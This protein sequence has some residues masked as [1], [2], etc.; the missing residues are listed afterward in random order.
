MHSMKFLKATD[1][2]SGAFGTVIYQLLQTLNFSIGR[3]S[4]MITLNAKY[5]A[6]IHSKYNAFSVMATDNPGGIPSFATT[7][8]VRVCDW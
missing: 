3:D 8:T 1:I 5:N 6:S 7:A 2:D 4:G